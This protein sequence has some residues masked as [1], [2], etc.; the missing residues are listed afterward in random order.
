MDIKRSKKVKFSRRDN[1]SFAVEGLRLQ[2]KI[3]QMFLDIKRSKKV[4]F[5]RRDN[6]SFAVEGLRLQTK[7]LQKKIITKV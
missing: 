6:L 4:I 1:L 3:L 7:I 2:T 5:S